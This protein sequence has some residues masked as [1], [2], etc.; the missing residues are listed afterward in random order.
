MQIYD[1]S[2]VIAQ[3]YIIKSDETIGF[4]DYSW[5][6]GLLMNSKSE[7]DNKNAFK[8]ALSWVD[9]ATPPWSTFFIKGSMV[10]EGCKPSE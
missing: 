5:K 3:S 2:G 8:S 6:A 9:K 1:I 4:I 10:D 7:S